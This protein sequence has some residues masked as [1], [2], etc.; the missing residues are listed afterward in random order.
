MSPAYTETSEV[1][2][3][4]FGRSAHASLNPSRGET[5]MPVLGTLIL[6]KP[7]FAINATEILIKVG[8]LAVATSELESLTPADWLNV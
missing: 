1:Y 7:R 3:L 4:H 5:S 2:W 6:Y 8:P